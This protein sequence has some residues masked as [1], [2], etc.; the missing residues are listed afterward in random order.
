VCINILLIRDH[1]SANYTVPSEFLEEHAEKLGLIEHEDKPQ[2]RPYLSTR[3]WVRQRR[4]QNDCHVQT[5][6]RFDN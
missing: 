5:Q 2:S 6:L 1:A 4:E 3:A